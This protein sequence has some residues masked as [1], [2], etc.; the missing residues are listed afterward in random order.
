MVLG[1]VPVYAATYSDVSD[2]DKE[3]VEV[4]SAFKII[5]GYEDGTFRGEGTITRSEFA[6][7]A[8]RLMGYEDLSKV[9]VD[10]IFPDVPS[11]HWASGYVATAQQQ[12]IINGFPDGNFYPE[13]LVTYEQ[14]VKML[15]CVLG[16]EPMAAETGYPTGYLY[17]AAQ[18]GVTTGFSG[19]IGAGASR[20]LVANLTYN[21]LNADL[22]ERVVW[23]TGDKNYA[24]NPNKS[25]LTEYLNGVR[26]KDYVS[27]NEYNSADLG[28]VELGTSSTAYYVGTTNVADYLGQRVIAYATRPKLSTD[29]RTIVAVV[30]DKTAT[31]FDIAEEL[32]A[33]VEAIAGT[34]HGYK[35]TY[36]TDP[37]ADKTS[38]FTFTNNANLV[39]D[40][41]KS[42]DRYLVE[43]GS[44]APTTLPKPANLIFVRNEDSTT[45]DYDRVIA[46]QYESIVVKSV[47]A[48][49]KTIKIDDK[50]YATSKNGTISYDIKKD[51][52]MTLVDTLGEEVDPEDL[53]EGDVITYATYK[54]SNRTYYRGVVGSTSIDGTVDDDATR[55]GAS[56]AEIDDTVYTVVKGRI[57][58]G[59]EGKFILDN[60]G[61]IVDFDKDIS[62]KGAYGVIS[63][64]GTGTSLTVVDTTGE[65]IE[66]T[67]ASKVSVNDGSKVTPTAVRGNG[68]FA[69]GKLISYVTD[70]ANKVTNVYLET[71]YT[72]LKQDD[73]LM[74]ANNGGT[75]EYDAGKKTLDFTIA[76][77]IG[78]PVLSGTIKVDG[79]TE[80]FV[81]KY[82]GGY[83]VLDPTS[84]S[85]DQVFKVGTRVLEVD[86]SSKVAGAIIVPA[87]YLADENAELVLL[88]SIKTGNKG[89]DDGEKYTQ[90]VYYSPSQGE[91]EAYDLFDDGVGVGWENSAAIVVTNEDGRVTDVIR[92]S[93]ANVTGL[94]GPYGSVADFK[95]LAN[96][97]GAEF[98]VEDTYYIPATLYRDADNSDTYKL[99]ATGT[100]AFVASDFTGVNAAD[101]TSKLNKALSIDDLDGDIVV[102]DPKGDDKYASY[103]D[104][105]FLVPGDGYTPA[106]FKV[107]VK[108]VKGTVVQI[109]G[110]GT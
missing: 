28:K 36:Y 17:A 52:Y 102:Y 88:K 32:I 47:S 30:P 58:S 66:L 76:D 70:S 89:Y 68:S 39:L 13:E 34:S 46:T 72:A 67:L 107:V 59:S 101:L 104:A 83:T 40:G 8:D 5:Q 43:G 106:S 4:L 84:L 2:A 105:D 15:M 94:A 21:A 9:Q 92:A 11:T 51:K 6:A 7:V 27:N 60:N 53:T 64:V 86:E 75:V 80:L 95:A 18:A 93:T 38:S 91:V 108:V 110:Y 42:T 20:S 78:T 16:Y 81:A 45:T 73:G 24:V 44:P 3:A 61:R 23:G 12:G 109:V 98:S 79:N 97:A 37:I 74:I 90:Y 29:P 100:T 19:T 87:Q 1:L 33:S 63:D 82:N 41:S 77:V 26:V 54:R 57:K 48:S 71:G 99:Y 14:A 56:F 85:T 25:A 31:R 55:G 50:E 49:G 69:V 22:M 96:T 103:A 65:E 35:V 62:N 10:T